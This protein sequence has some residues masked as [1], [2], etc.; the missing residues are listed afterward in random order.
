MYTYN[1]MWK[2]QNYFKKCTRVIGKVQCYKQ[3][4]YMGKGGGK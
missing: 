4:F 1:N 2:Q 3:H